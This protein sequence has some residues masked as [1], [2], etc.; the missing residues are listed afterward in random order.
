M[1]SLLKSVRPLVPTGAS[2]FSQARM[3][4]EALRVPGAHDRGWRS[5]VFRADECGDLRVVRAR[6]V[7]DRI[8]AQ[9]AIQLEFGFA[10][11][12]FVPF[13]ETAFGELF[14]QRRGCRIADGG[15]TWRNCCPR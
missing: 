6:V 3:E 9:K 12:Q 7:I 8:Q 1:A 15:W 2:V 5:G 10:D 13:Y 11:G 14:L 4:S